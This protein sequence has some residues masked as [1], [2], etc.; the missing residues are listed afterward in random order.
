[1]RGIRKMGSR[2]PGASGK[3]PKIFILKNLFFEKIMRSYTYVGAAVM[4]GIV[5]RTPRHL[6]GRL[7][8]GVTL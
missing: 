6:E 7:S 3:G 8:G 1:M 2:A 4:I 5:D